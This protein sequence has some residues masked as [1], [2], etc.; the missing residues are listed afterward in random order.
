M[1]YLISL[2]KASLIITTLSISD[3]KLVNQIFQII[4]LISMTSLTSMPLHQIIN[5]LTVIKANHLDLNNLRL[6]K[7]NSTINLDFKINHLGNRII[8][9]W[10]HLIDNLWMHF[11]LNLHLNH[12]I[13]SRNNLI[14]HKNLQLINHKHHFNLKTLEVLNLQM[15]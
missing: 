7:L 4:K 8:I 1:I 5:F 11:N 10:N 9:N 14:I 2:K 6:S 12:R 13:S 15:L 3:L